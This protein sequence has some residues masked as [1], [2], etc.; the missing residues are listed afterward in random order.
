MKCVNEK[1]M[2]KS[3][4]ETKMVEH[5]QKFDALWRE[6]VETVNEFKKDN[7][8]TGM[9]SMQSTRIDRIIDTLCL[10]GAWIHDRIEG[11]MCT[12]HSSTYKK[13][14]TKKVRKA[15]GYTL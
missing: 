1:I 14:L 2:N 11:Y 7:P 13:T 4:F 12:P 15:L 10:S 6:I 9:Y 8:D 5:E 3:E